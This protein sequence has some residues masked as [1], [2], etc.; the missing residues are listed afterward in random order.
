MEKPQK[1]MQLFLHQNN[2]D[3]QT[4]TK[5]HHHQTSTESRRKKKC[6]FCSNDGHLEEHCWTKKRIVRD[7]QAK[8]SSKANLARHVPQSLPKNGRPSFFPD[9]YAFTSY[10]LA[11]ISKMNDSRVNTDWWIDLGTT[12]P[13]LPRALLNFE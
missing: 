8:A 4:N 10:L 7:L 5:N 3:V 6:T 11:L 12:Q 13:D 9:D 1:K 2:L